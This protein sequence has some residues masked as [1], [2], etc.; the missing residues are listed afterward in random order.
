MSPVRIREAGYTVEKCPGSVAAYHDCLSRNRLGFE[1]R[2]GRRFVLGK[3]PEKENVFFECF[4]VWLIRLARAPRLR[5]PRG[6][7]RA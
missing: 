7:R 5:A 2:P 4:L 6:A 3:F 1:F